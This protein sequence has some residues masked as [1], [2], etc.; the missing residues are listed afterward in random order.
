MSEDKRPLST[1]SLMHETRTFPPSGEVVKRVK[2][3]GSL[4]SEGAALHLLF[5]LFVNGQLR[6]RKVDG[7]RDMPRDLSQDSDEKTPLKQAD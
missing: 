5:G 3:Q 4:P 1:D 6:M 2:V 7:W